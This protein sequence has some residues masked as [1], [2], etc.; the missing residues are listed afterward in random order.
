MKVSVTF[1]GKL[2]DLIY[3]LPCVIQ[4]KKKFD[5]QITYVTSNK[6]ESLIRLLEEQDY[7]DKVKIDESYQ[8]ESED[9][10]CQPWKMSDDAE[11]DVTYHLGYRREII[12]RWNYKRHLIDVPFDIMDECY[13]ISLDRVKDKQY[14]SAG[15]ST[16]SNLVIFHGIG[17]TISQLMDQKTRIYM[18]S[19]WEDIIKSIDEG[20]E[21]IS[22]SDESSM[23]DFLGKKI[24]TPFDMLSVAKII[25]GSKLLI[26][27]Q[28]VCAAIENGL[29]HPRLILNTFEN[30][31]PTCDNFVMFSISEKLNNILP[32]LKNKFSFIKT[33]NQDLNCLST[34]NWGNSPIGL[35]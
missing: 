22:K 21:I 16:Y 32:R 33:V 7:I 27:C 2:G 6:C 35:R 11:S 34:M 14:L 28:S 26:G 3:T 20:V 5:C 25:S 23:F 19:K 1:P 9:C 18:M 24:T 30:A 29:N 13:G 8:V 31:V 12:T 10:G 17:E 15:K 4:I